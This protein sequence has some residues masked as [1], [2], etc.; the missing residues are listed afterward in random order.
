MLPRIVTG[1]CSTFDGNVKM[2]YVCEIKW[3][4]DE[5]KEEKKNKIVQLLST[6]IRAK[7]FN[8]ISTAR[9]SHWNR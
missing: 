6:S 5:K 4:R 9:R 1:N 3:Q 2:K 7:F 8:S